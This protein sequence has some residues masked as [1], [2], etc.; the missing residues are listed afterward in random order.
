MTDALRRT[1]TWGLAIG[2]LAFAIG[3]FGPMILAPD[4]NQGPLLGIFITGPLG[5]LLGL[6]VGIVRESRGHTASPLAVLARSRL[7]DLHHRLPLRFAAAVSAIV[8]IPYGIAGVRRGEGRP[9]A[10]SIVVGAALL[11]FAAAGEMPAW[12]RR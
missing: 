10:A 8:L 12:F 1:L 4:A 3:F 6:A 5:L 7:L 11:W 9:A 2:G